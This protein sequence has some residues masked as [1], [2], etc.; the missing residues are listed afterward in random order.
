MMHKLERTT[1]ESSRAGEYFDTRELQA[2]T[3]QPS[4]NFATVA[5]KELADNALDACETAGVAPEVS[6][7]V[8]EKGELIWLT[9]SDNGPGI[10]PETLR[11]VLNFNTRTSDKAAYRSPTRGAQGNALKTVVGI[12]HALGGAEPLVIEARGVRHQIRAWV[13]PAGEPRIDYDDHR[14]DGSGGTRVGLS[15]PA[16]DQVFDPEYWAR[17]YA[18]FN[19][20]ALVK[21]QQAAGST[22]QGNSEAAEM[23]HSYHPTK[24]FPDE[25]RKYLPGDPTSPHWYDAAAL[26]RL[27]FSNIAHARSGGPDLPLREFVRQFKGLTATKKAKAVCDQ[28]PPV[29]RLSDFEDEPEAVAD[30]LRAMWRYSTAPTHS[31]L[32]VVGREHF[33]HC[34]SVWYG[35]ER[36][37]YKKIK[38]HLPSGLPYVFEFAL[39]ETEEKG[40]LFTAVNY[41]PTFD[42]PLEGTRFEGLGYPVKGIGELLV[43]GH[44]HPDLRH[45]DDLYRPFTA[46]A[47]HIATPA[48]LFLDRGKTRLLLEEETDG[49]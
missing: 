48:P 46:A 31:V 22:Y 45:P 30:L 14:T 21:I 20:H 42:D 11:K 5:L 15:I 2:Q 28:F 19:P 26:K 7:E 8:H 27:V 41:S 39:A 12:P 3:G 29:R 33:R 40:D 6:V 4:S 36:F 13:D 43:A 9:V 32:G 25:F 10:P 18:L 49:S 23:V 35:V 47:V 37:G 44:A 16:Q 24:L 38:G 34:F 1:F 17:A